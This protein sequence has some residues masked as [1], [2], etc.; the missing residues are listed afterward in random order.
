M[1]VTDLSLYVSTG[2]KIFKY[3]FLVLSPYCRSLVAPESFKI[4]DMNKMNPIRLIF[5]T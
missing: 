3:K 2:K 4:Q 5:P 1:N